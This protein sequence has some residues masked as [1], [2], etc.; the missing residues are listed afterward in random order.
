MKFTLFI[1]RHLIVKS[2]EH[3]A[4]EIPTALT[5]LINLKNINLSYNYL[6]GE[7]SESSLAFTCLQL[8][9]FRKVGLLCLDVI[10]VHLLCT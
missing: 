1:F 7:I 5:Q 6:S 2:F 10:C 8:A 4:G 3:F 9:V